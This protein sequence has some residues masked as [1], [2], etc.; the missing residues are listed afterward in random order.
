M[1]KKAQL[2]IDMP[3]TCRD[4]YFH[5]SGEPDWC[6]LHVTN[7]RDIENENIRQ[8]WCPLKPLPKRKEDV[9]EV[10]FFN[11]DHKQDIVK[12]GVVR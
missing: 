6:D 4:C 1:N 7:Y 2:I 5:Q 3:E 9:K 11:Y 12:K 8:K 10:Y